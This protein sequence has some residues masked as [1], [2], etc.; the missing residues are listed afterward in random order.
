MKKLLLFIFISYGTIGFSQ[1]STQ[2]K[3]NEVFGEEFFADN[4]D[5]FDF[6]V[7]LLDTR[8]SFA[9]EP[10]SP[11]DKY[12]KIGDAG[13]ANK[14]NSSITPFVPEDFSVETFNPVRYQLDYYQSKL[15]KVYRIDATNYLLIIQPQ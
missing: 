8:I 9:E 11:D 6:W 1:L 15:T 14:L 12:E 3:I 13:L 2:E 7:N 5:G 10:I 4:Q